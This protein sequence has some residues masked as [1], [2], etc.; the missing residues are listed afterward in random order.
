M[1]PRPA[2]GRTA[3]YP[4]AESSAAAPWVL[5]STEAC[6]EQEANKLRCN[7][8]INLI[9]QAAAAR[10]LEKH[11]GHRPPLSKYPLRPSW[12]T[13]FLPRCFELEKMILACF[14]KSSTPG[15]AAA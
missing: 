10:E 5:H 6:Q 15:L 11:K 3:A 7:G 14:A 9:P 2:V 8:V 1:E 13:V 4:C 12:G